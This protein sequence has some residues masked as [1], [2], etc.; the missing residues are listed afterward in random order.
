MVEPALAEA[1]AAEFATIDGTTAGA[2]LGVV[3]A[4]VFEM[5]ELVAVAAEDM[6]YSV[7]FGDTV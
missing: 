1:F 3:N 6:S 4:I 5:D 7:A 2:D